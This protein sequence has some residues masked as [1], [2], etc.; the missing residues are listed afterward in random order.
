MVGLIV[1]LYLS[2]CSKSASPQCVVKLNYSHCCL[3]CEQ[4]Y[5][6]NGGTASQFEGVVLR[7][8]LWY[9]FL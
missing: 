9:V 5:W 7:A 4:S 6:T 1:C 8:D 3:L 2:L